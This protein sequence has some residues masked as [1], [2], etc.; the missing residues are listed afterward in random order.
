MVKENS[1]EFKVYGRRA[2]FSEPFSRVGGEKFS[3]QIPTYQ[4]LKGITESIYWK[5]TFSWVIEKVRVMKSIQ[6]ESIGIRPINYGGGNTLSYYTYL[7]DVEYYVKAHFEWNKNRPNLEFD[8]DENKHFFIAKRMLERGG[9]RDIYLGTRECQGYVEPCCFGDGKGDYD[10]LEELSFGMMVHGLTYPDDA[11]REDEK[12]KLTVRFWN[13]VMKKGVVEFIRPEAC[14]TRRS[15]QSMKK[16]K[17]GDG[18]FTGLKEFDSL[19]KEGG[20]DLYGMDAG[21]K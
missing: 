17:F 15:V 18:D 21:I 3:Y 9:R 19:L 12:E 2:L 13:P 8:R 14:I 4:A 20:R 6:T 16:T 11:E 7:R 10:E 1:I 5:P